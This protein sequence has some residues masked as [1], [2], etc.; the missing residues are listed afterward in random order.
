[1][2][3][4]D[5][6]AAGI[7]AFGLL[8]F[9]SIFLFAF[10][11]STF[12]SEELAILY[13][14]N[15]LHIDASQIYVHGG[16]YFTGLG[17]HFIT[18]N[19]LYRRVHIDNER[20]R[21]SDG[22][23]FDL[24]YSYTYQINDN[25]DDLYRFYLDFGEDGEESTIFQSFAASAVHDVASRYTAFEYFEKRELINEAMKEK[26]NTRLH[27]VYAKI[28]TFQI[29]NMEV[30]S[31]FADV[32]EETQVAIQEV[33]VQTQEKAKVVVKAAALLAVAEEKSKITVA[34]SAATAGALNVAVQAEGE[35]LAYR[36]Q[37]QGESLQNLTTTWGPMTTDNILDYLYYSA[38]RESKASAL[39][40]SSAFPAGVDV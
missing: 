3:G 18:F 37:L 20:V 8:L 34:L 23:P 32:I 39:H 33:D 12:A 19:S 25:I 13:D 31:Q 10:S 16:R 4:E 9:I 36:L 15:L 6:A 35:A 2:C 30:A 7:M 1:M 11:F 29:T 27:R 28:T 24:S 21:A 22:L 40:F 26:V 14:A 17:T 5:G 38:L